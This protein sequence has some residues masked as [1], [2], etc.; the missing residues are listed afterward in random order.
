MD[1]GDHER[2]RGHLAP[3]PEPGPDPAG[4]RGLAGAQRPVQ[5]HQVSGAQQPGQARGPAPRYR[6]QWSVPTSRA[7]PSL[8][9]TASRTALTASLCSSSTTCP[10]CGTTTSSASGSTSQIASRMLDRCQ[11]V[12]VAADDQHRDLGHRAERHRP[13]VGVERTQVAGDGLHPGG[14]VHPLHIGHQRRADLLGAEP[15]PAGEQA[16]QVASTPRGPGPPCRRVTQPAP[17]TSGSNGLRKRTSTC[18]MPQVTPS[19]SPAEVEMSTTPR[20][21]A[22]RLEQLGLGVGQRHDGHPAHRVADQHHPAGRVRSPRSPGAAPSRASSSVYS[23]RSS[24]PERPCPGWSKQTVRTPGTPRSARRWKWNVPMSR[25]KPCTNT[26]V[27]G[28]VGS[29]SI[30]TCSA[31]PSSW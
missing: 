23:P 28:A 10:A 26:T 7:S 12:L 16:G 20:D 1:P 11:Q 18:G 8:G 24:R 3:H 14:G 31:M 25:Q 21:P 4:Q 6:P 17:E 30:S 9:R 29:P 15:V 27:S 5:D 2:R 19:S 13:V 22:V